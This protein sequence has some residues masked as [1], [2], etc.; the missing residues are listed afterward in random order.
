MYLLNIS[1]ATL[2]LRLMG[3]HVRS[4]LPATR[5]TEPHAVAHT[6]IC[7]HAHS[8]TWTRKHRRRHCHWHS[9][10]WAQST[11]SSLCPHVPVAGAVTCL[12]ASAT[13]QQ[14]CLTVGRECV[15]TGQGPTMKGVALRACKECLPREEHGFR[16][17]KVPGRAVVRDTEQPPILKPDRPGFKSP[18]PDF[19]ME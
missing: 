5:H 13:S 19:L 12:W 9:C 1:S 17:K 6:Q 8:D 11:A 2:T 10:A 15:S 7:V 16:M 14:G 4:R 18:L 3:P